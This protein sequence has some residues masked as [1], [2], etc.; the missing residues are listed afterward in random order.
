MENRE[1]VAKEMNKLE[2]EKKTESDQKAELQA[3][4]RML[5]ALSP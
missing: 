2:S 5:L 1:K 4:V 3:K